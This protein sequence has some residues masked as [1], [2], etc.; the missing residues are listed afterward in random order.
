MFEDIQ[1]FVSGS[2][3]FTDFGTNKI[4]GKYG[5]LNLIGSSKSVSELEV[6]SELRTKGMLKANLV[7]TASYEGSGV[8]EAS[9]LECRVGTHFGQFKCDHVK[10]GA[11]SVEGLLEVDSIDAGRVDLRLSSEDSISQIGQVKAKD[12]V[13]SHTSGKLIVNSLEATF[14]S[15]EHTK[16]SQVVGVNV[17]IGPGCEIE[18]V[19]YTGSLEVDGSA[20]VKNRTSPN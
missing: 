13:V 14:I 2:Q 7:K 18:N 19:I 5:H 10:A 3:N 11:L 20:T 8:F 1:R 12:F 9:T 6:E 4:D 17:R 15:I 16:A